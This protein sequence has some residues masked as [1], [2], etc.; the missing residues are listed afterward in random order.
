[1]FDFRQLSKKDNFPPREHASNIH[2]LKPIAAVTSLQTLNNIA[3]AS[4][5]QAGIKVRH[6]NFGEG[7][8]LSVEGTDASSRKA[9][10]RFQ[11]SGERVLLLK[12]AKLE[13]IQ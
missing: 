6:A 5:I 13:I 11:T 4:K 7:V 10:I 2:R 9:V 12:Y 1:M 3:D 8:V